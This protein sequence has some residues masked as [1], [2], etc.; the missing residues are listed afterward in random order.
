MDLAVLGVDLAALGMDL[1][2]LGVDRVALGV[3]RV[4][5]FRLDPTPKYRA[6]PWSDLA[7]VGLSSGSIWEC[8]GS[9]WVLSENVWECFGSLWVCSG[10]GL[11]VL[12]LL[13]ESIWLP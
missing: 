6:R 13:L 2:A 4:G 5:D 11:G 9:A 12:W 3:N 8:S 7:L 1:A 10:S